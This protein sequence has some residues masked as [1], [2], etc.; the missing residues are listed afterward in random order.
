MKKMLL[1][2]MAMMLCLAFS[3]FAGDEEGH[4]GHDHSGHAHA[5]AEA[6]WFDMPN[7]DFCKHLIKDENL[8]PNMKWEHLDISNGVVTITTVEDDY[9]GAYKEAQSAMMALGT[10][11]ESGKVNFAD[12]KMCG[13]CQNYGMLM[14]AGASFEYVQGEGADVV[15]ISGDNEELIAKIKKFGEKNRTELAKMHEAK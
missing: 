2:A 14:Q 6:P 1:I 10:D 8:L 15:I 9:K 7:C 13:F 11:M 12:V 3:S 4:E 5:M